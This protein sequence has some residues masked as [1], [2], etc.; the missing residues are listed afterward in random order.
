VKS[1]EKVSSVS[2]FRLT[3]VRYGRVPKRS[4]ERPADEAITVNNNNNNCSPTAVTS[5]PTTPVL[6]S[7]TQQPLAADSAGAGNMPLSIESE[8]DAAALMEITASITAAHTAHC[9][10]TS[11]A[12]EAT[13]NSCP[14]TASPDSMDSLTL[15][16]EQDGRKRISLWQSFASLLTPCVQRVVEFAKRVPGE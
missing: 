11:H 2:L 5:L 3:A 14:R 7:P 16:P 12:D 15:L 10:Y 4:R 13:R 8:A 9:N 6:A 1:N